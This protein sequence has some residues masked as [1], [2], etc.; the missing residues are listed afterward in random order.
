VGAVKLKRIAAL[1]A[2]ALVATASGAGAAASS[3]VPS[4]INTLR[5]SGA[6]RT[7]SRAGVLYACLRSRAT[8]LGSLRGSVPFPARRVARYA[9]SPRYAGVATLDMG[10]DTLAS[11]VALIDLRSGRTLERAPATSPQRAAESFSTVTEMRVNGDGVLAWIGRRS[12]IGDLQPVYELHIFAPHR[13]GGVF[14]DSTIALVDLALNEK[15]L[16]YRFA[17]AGKRVVIALPL[18]D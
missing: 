18:P 9:L 10:V 14:A 16:S 6:A 17:H 2:V 1:A 5:A 15:R 4:G 8:R 7:Y 11:T 13:E 12:A 3:C